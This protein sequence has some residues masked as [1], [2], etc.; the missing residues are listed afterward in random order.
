[1]K[2][3]SLENY[4]KCFH[5]S[6]KLCLGIPQNPFLEIFKHHPALGENVKNE[7]AQRGTGREN[8]FREETFSKKFLEYSERIFTSQNRENLPRSGFCVLGIFPGAKRREN[9]WCVFSRESWEKL[10]FHKI[11]FEKN[12]S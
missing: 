7:D 6:P 12:L 1:M 4:A 3:W 5:G 11:K 8:F 9:N 2:S 10:E